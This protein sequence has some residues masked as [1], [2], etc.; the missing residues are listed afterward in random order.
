M[1]WRGNSGRNFG[2]LRWHKIVNSAKDKSQ[3]QENKSGKDIA[4][5]ISEKQTETE[6]IIPDKM[7]RKTKSNQ[8]EILLMKCYRSNKNQRKIF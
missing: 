5:K 6:K 2:A 7:S 8:Q 1:D 3:M 4:G